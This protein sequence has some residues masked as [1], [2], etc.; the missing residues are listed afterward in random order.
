MDHTTNDTAV[1]VSHGSASRGW[2]IS[3]RTALL[4]TLVL[5]TPLTA[6]AQS[7]SPA[8]GPGVPALAADAEF[9]ARDHAQ[10]RRLRLFG[11]M[12]VSGAGTCFAGFVGWM[13]SDINE[14]TD[15]RASRASGTFA[16]AGLS[17]GLTGVLGL[18]GTGIRRRVARHRW[19]ALRLEPTL[20]LGLRGVDSAGLRASLTW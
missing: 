1:A 7:E 11:V 20:E 9:A 16:V 3:A 19:R 6:R 18:L 14:G 13:L 4:A 15:V 2:V 8:Q 5:M 12:V 10:T 17:A